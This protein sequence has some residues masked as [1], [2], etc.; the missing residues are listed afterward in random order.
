ME[1]S[2]AE[3]DGLVALITSAVEDVKSEY[4]RLNLSFPRLTDVKPHP[5]DTISVPQ[6]LKTAVQVINGACAQLS[7]L[8][9]P[10]DQATFVVS[11]KQSTT[12]TIVLQ[13]T[14]SSF[15]AGEQCMW[16]KTNMI[17]S[18]KILPAALE[19]RRCTRGHREQ[20]CRYP[21]RS[22]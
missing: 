7:T 1:S 21:R 8:V 5:L 4:R 20:D 16:S 9:L 19:F 11:P 12:S 15:T 10:V 22:S 6:N 3:L 17:R 14:A 2:F 18:T 13:S